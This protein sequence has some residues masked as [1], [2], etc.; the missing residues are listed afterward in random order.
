MPD[1][2]TGRVAVALLLAAPLVLGMAPTDRLEQAV[3]AQRALVEAHPGDAGALNDLGNL[4]VEVGEV[5]AAEEAYRLALEADPLRPE[6]HFNLALLLH[7]GGQRKLA[8][9]QL[10]T[11]LSEHP[12]H[13]WG[14]YQLGILHAE[15]GRRGRALSSFRQALRLNPSL[16]DP[17]VN[18]HIIDNSMATAA[19][20]QAFDEVVSES[21]APRLYADPSRITGLLLPRLTEQ[22]REPLMDK[23]PEP[24]GETAAE[25]TA[26]PETE[27]P[28]G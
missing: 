16:A 4:L 21:A 19:M 25:E 10:E 9:Q 7:A 15:H 11:L 26:E 24:P 12:D 2:N 13:A 20:L 8:R 28:P 5:E 6:P 27:G 22:P 1:H 3:I 14:H 23:K 17:R 18:P